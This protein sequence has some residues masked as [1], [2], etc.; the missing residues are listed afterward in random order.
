[1]I[2]SS[3]PVMTIFIDGVPYCIPIHIVF[4][5]FYDYLLPIVPVYFAKK[6]E[7]IYMTVIDICCRI[8][9]HGHYVCSTWGNYHFK[10]FDGA[11]YQFPGSCSYNMASHCQDSYQ[12]FSVHVHR[13]LA[14]GHPF[15]DKITI[16]IKDVIVQMKKNLV[17]LNGAIIKTP[18]YSFG[19]LIHE[20]DAYFKMY[21]KAGLT[22][23][24]NRED[25]VMLELDPR[26]NNHTC[27]LCGDY[28]GDPKNS[29]FL[30]EDRTFSPITFGNQQNVNDPNEVCLD[31]EETEVINP[32]NCSK[33]RSACEEHLGHAAFS[34]CMTFL[35]LEPYIKACMIDMCS[36]DHS[37]DSFCLCSTITE[38]SRQ[39]S[40]AGGRPGN[41]RSSKFCPK[42]CPAN[43]VYQESAS[44]CKNSCSHQ[45]IHSLCEE[46]YMDGC[47][48]PD[49]TVLDDYTD[50][51]CI[52][53]TKCHCKHQG[54]LYAP[55]ESIKK[56]CDKCRCVAGRWNCTDL[57]CPKVCSIEGGA[58]FTTFDGKTYTFHGNCNYVLLKARCRLEN[59][60]NL[61]LGNLVPCR[62]SGKETC[63]SSVTLVTDNQKSV[64]MFRADGT[65]FLNNLKVTLPH[66]TD[67]FS[68]LQPSKHHIIVQTIHGLQMQIQLLPKMQLYI[69][70]E[71]T[72]RKP[73]Q[74]LCGN[75]NSKEVDDFTTSGGLVEATASAFANSWKGLDSCQDISDR[76]DS[77]CSVSIENKNYADYW[78]SKLENNESVFAKCHSAIDPSEYAKRCRYDSCNC[79]ESEQCMC[80]AL[81][82]Y[83]RACAAK[84]IILWGW[85][86]GICDK[87]ITSCP[88]SQ[89]YLYNLTTCQLT[90]RSLAEGE[91]VCSSVFTPVDGCG[92]PDGQYLNE[93][94]Q[95]VPKSKCSC[96]YRDTYLKPQERITTKDRQCICQNGNLVCPSQ[97]NKTCSGGKVYFDCNKNQSLPS[98]TTIH[99]SCK[100]LS[101]EY[102]Q[103][104]CISGCVC[105]NG[106]LDDG[107]GGCVPEDRCPCVHNE[108]IYPHGT[109][110]KVDCNTCLCQRGRW[111]CTDTVCHGTCTIYGNGHYITFDDKIYDF[112][113]NCE[114]V[115]AQDY[116]ETESSG[117]SFSVL[118]ENIPCG[119]TGVTCSKSVKVFLGNTMLKLSEKHVVKTVGEG[120]K[121]IDYLTR[122]VGIYL[123]IEASNGILLIWDKKTTIFIKVSPAYK[124]KLCGLCGNF[125][126]N[127][128]NDFKTRHMIQVIDVLEFGNSW[129]V[130]ATCPDATDVVNPCS[131]NPHRHSWAEKQCSLIKS[132]IFKICHSKVDPKPFYE[133]CVNDACSCDSG[134]DCE[135]FCTAVAAYAQEC[136]KAEACVYWRT[137]DI[138]PIFCDYYNPMGECEWHYHPCGNHS[139]QTCRSIN[140]IYTNVTITYL[141]GCYPTCPKN[142]PIFDEVN[143]K[144]VTRDECGCY[145]NDVHHKSGAEVPYYKKCYK[146]VCASNGNISCKKLDDSSCSSTTPL[147]TT[148]I[149]P[150]T[151]S[152]TA[153]TEDCTPV[154]SWSK[155]L[156]SSIPSFASRG[157]YETYDNIRKAGYDVCGSPQK[158]SC[159]AKHRPN[160]NLYSLGQI[161]VCD[162]S[163]GLICYN[164]E[165]RP[166][167]ICYDYEIRVYCC[168]V[169]NTC[170]STTG[171]NGT[172]TPASIITTIN[173]SGT[174][175]PTILMSKSPP[176][177]KSLTVTRPT[178]SISQYETSTPTPGPTVVN[179][180]STSTQDCTPICSW[181]QWFSVSYPTYESGGDYETYHNIRQ[182]GYDVCET[183]L[184]ISCRAKRHPNT[185]LHELR[186]KVTC[187]VSYGLICINKEQDIVPM[188]EDYEISVYCCK[189]PDMCLHT[190]PRSLEYKSSIPVIISTSSAGTNAT[191]TWTLTRT[192]KI[193]KTSSH[194]SSSTSH[195]TSSPT[196]TFGIG[197]K[198]PQVTSKTTLHLPQVHT[199]KTRTKATTITSPAR[200]SKGPESTPASTTKTPFTTIKPSP[201][202]I[203]VP[204]LS[205]SPPTNTSFIPSTTS[206][207]TFPNATSSASTIENKL[208]S[209]TTSTPKTRKYTSSKSVVTS[210]ST[211]SATIPITNITRELFT[212]NKT[213][214]TTDANIVTSTKLIPTTNMEVT[215]AA[216]MS[217]STSSQGSYTP[218]KPM[219]IT[220][221]PTATRAASTFPTD[222]VTKTRQH[223]EMTTISSTTSTTV[224]SKIPTISTQNELMQTSATQVFTATSNRSPTITTS[225][226]SNTTKKHTPEPTT[227]SAASIT[228]S[229]RTVVTSIPASMT[230]TTYSKTLPTTNKTTKVYTTRDFLKTSSTKSTLGSTPKGIS[231]TSQISRESTSYTH[232]TPDSSSKANTFTF[233]STTPMTTSKVTTKYISRPS[234][235]H[236][237]LSNTTTAT[238][239][240]NNQL[241]PIIY[242]PSKSIPTL[243]SEASRMTTEATSTGSFRTATS[244]STS[245]MPSTIPKQPT[246]QSTRKSTNP[247]LSEFTTSSMTTTRQTR[248]PGTSPTEHSMS[249][250]STTTTSLLTSSTLPTTVK[251][252]RSSH[253]VCVHNGIP[254]PPGEVISKVTNETWC[255]KVTCNMEC[256]TEVENW[257]CSTSTPSSTSMPALKSTSSPSF[258]STTPQVFSTIYSTAQRRSSASVITSMVSS[259]TERHG[260]SFE[261]FRE[262]NETWMLNNCTMAK[263]LEDHTVEI[264]EMK[265]EP[266]P[267][268][269][270]ANGYLPIAVPDDN[271]CCWH[272]ECDCVCSGWGDPHYKTFDGT[273]YTFQGICTYTLMEEIE[274]K[275]NLRIYIDNYDCGTNDS[276]SCPRKLIVLHNT[277]EIQLFVSDFEDINIQ[278]FANGEIV[279]TPY[280]KNGVKIYTLGIYYVVEIPELG[281]NIIYNGLGFYIK[282]PYYHFGDNTQ[283]QC[284]TCTN[285]QSDDCRTRDGNIVS[286]CEMM[287]DSWIIEDSKKPECG[288][289]KTT[290][291]PNVT[292]AP[293]VTPTCQP[294][295]L[296]SLLMGPLFQKCHNIV[297]PD[298]F[299]EACVYDSCHV[300]RSKIE[301]SSLQHYAQLCGDEGICID[302]RSKAPECSM[303][304]PSHKVYNACGPAV[305]RT[306]KTIPEENSIMKDDEHF[307]EGCFCPQDSIR[308]SPAVDICVN[309]CGC[310]GPDN[311]PR[312]FG[313][314]FQFGCQDCICIEG[315]SGITCQ[316]HKCKEM[317]EVH[318]TLEGFS[319]EVQISP[320]DPCCRETVCRC[321]KSRCNTMSPICELG[322]EAVASIPEG[323]CC[324]QYECDQGTK[325]SEESSHRLE[326]EKGADT[327]QSAEENHIDYIQV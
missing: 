253:C 4:F 75:F 148:S 223:T 95:C 212:T 42:Q 217:F 36:C 176:T 129:K 10:T 221:A 118:T 252:T 245:H 250:A 293:T 283:G 266:P 174:T 289:T 23:M 123:V 319:S 91:K 28:N 195:V 225:S 219:P 128:Q 235:T 79:K 74:G 107:A 318:C 306:C 33:Y 37:Q 277:Q 189:V 17:V 112:D 194:T 228:S 180:T 161:V 40:H 200:T 164:K 162:I 282:L 88:S 58:H 234:S 157:D 249:E 187:D 30:F 108:D 43:M 26:F 201:T 298:D 165:Q 144:C 255:Y 224:T 16:S 68:I 209:S 244:R 133:A 175:A 202:T 24:W 270:C 285:N 168:T 325:T 256:K 117:G 146:C 239:S 111:T 251:E 105:P 206:T 257:L 260:C 96:H 167:P 267:V 204:I 127:S 5:L 62:S 60:T 264:I 11:F 87:D 122:E 312:K 106:L 183:P 119:T 102:F 8:R 171:P 155:W 32:E 13:L 268:I 222:K 208:T 15:I 64:V 231:T 139:V 216:S 66:F 47:F 294:S 114:F 98:R 220:T 263:C 152:P 203:S 178:S 218:T 92:C 169:S 191:T 286:K 149:T 272:W 274:K 22:L 90:C 72:S 210:V 65:V 147:T 69:T 78:C 136:T 177:T 186:Q 179:E 324:F 311:V 229:T 120:G 27:G 35:K 14:N 25:A 309:T 85:K 145:I 81:S 278:V 159:R 242:I 1:M 6:K 281:A 207:I 126:D 313:E 297:L 305:P 70:T 77:P 49:G 196:K 163:Y 246:T 232:I 237:A 288:Q 131:Q 73:L 215:T 156:S 80:A 320:T 248:T 57:P 140:H 9:N 192:T 151:I 172:T 279:G 50:R 115:A 310:V 241:T 198:T 199:T 211:S 51:G 243:P 307:V 197:I 181:S 291:P 83:V 103:T 34:D 3:S 287:A 247:F 141:E 109:Q 97:V 315:G 323:H 137:P 190:T 138:C 124:G 116:C 314:K 276:M 193:S 101:V 19:I 299:Y 316:K 99:R 110:V 67:N 100:T 284:G 48:C 188:C 213:P 38:Y 21:A 55:G 143:K 254:F 39:C 7:V 290:V 53:V 153:A 61:I 300:S 142:K 134:G 259:T 94:D 125:D 230:V 113:G 292:A 308:F 76:L 154:C 304:C 185:A 2:P 236:P 265:C 89:I 86:K 273:Y 214:L 327:R 261:K 132:H 258:L 44:P 226:T 84:G 271:Q 20:N 59:R 135:C 326:K 45:E 322:Y 63:L 280:Q 295:P 31:T 269:T 104:E 275:N 321:D 173:I 29:E 160:K 12:D 54:K 205:T 238:E 158:I 170:S 150:A 18:Y 240:N 82:S 227:A 182:A 303:S 302:W 121:H 296:C 301:C 317:T 93:K 184:H 130:D 46:H 71:K 262:P 166:L 41:W 233:T 56:D 52:P